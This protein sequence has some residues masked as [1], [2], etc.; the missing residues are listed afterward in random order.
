MADAGALIQELAGRNY[1]PVDGPVAVELLRKIVKAHA[2]FID[3]NDNG[4]HDEFQMAANAFYETIDVA[5]V[6]LE[7]R[8]LNE[9]GGE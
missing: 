9:K 5:E 4:S 6:W 3:R 7:T 2:F 1:S 8:G